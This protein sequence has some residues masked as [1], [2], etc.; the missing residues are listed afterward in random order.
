MIGR[1]RLCRIFLSSY[2]INGRF[3][4]RQ[5][6]WLISRLYYALHIAVLEIVQFDSNFHFRIGV[7]RRLAEHCKPFVGVIVVL[8]FS[9]YTADNAQF[10][11][12]NR[13]LVRSDMDK[14][15]P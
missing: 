12:G 9:N 13:H 1:L 4:F 7:R 14:R 6:R 10:V 2:T 15:V 3:I 11:I 5:S 8:G